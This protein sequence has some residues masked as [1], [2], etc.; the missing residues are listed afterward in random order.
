[1]SFTDPR[2]DE[3]LLAQFRT[4]L[5]EARG[6]AETLALSA[7]AGAP[8]GDDAAAEFGL[9]RLVEEFT[10]LRHELKLQ[11]KSARGLQEQVET[12]APALRHAVDRFRALESNE[13]A[14]DAV[15]RPLAAA[16]ADLHDALERGRAEIE[17]AQRRLDEDAEQAADLFDAL[18]ARQRWFRRRLTRSYHAQVAALAREQV[19]RPRRAIFEALAEGYDLIQSRLARAL[20]AERIARIECIGQPVD[21]ERMTVIELVV[22]GDRP[23]G[24]VVEEVRRGYTWQGRVLRFAEV[25]ASRAPYPPVERQTDGTDA[26]G[27]DVVDASAARADEAAMDAVRFPGESNGRM[28]FGDHE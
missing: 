27:G 1:M 10:A 13:Q 18:H 17:R 9:S 14:A 7:L 12:L 22:D 24:V 15:G 4:W 6:E 26:N 11:T 23:P 19:L 28:V 16:L 8:A 5:R 3:A 25:R 21:P 2:D 20:R